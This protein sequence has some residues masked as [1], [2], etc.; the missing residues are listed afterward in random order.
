MV[1]GHKRLLYLSSFKADLA[2]A[3]LYGKKS[4][5]VTPGNYSRNALPF[6][7]YHV[8]TNIK[9]ALLFADP[10]MKLYVLAADFLFTES[11]AIATVLQISL[12]DANKQL[13]FCVIKNANHQICLLESSLYVVECFLMV[14]QTLFSRF[15]DDQVMRMRAHAVS[16]FHDFLVVFQGQQAH[17]TRGREVL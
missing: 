4:A 3:L 10:V 17:F 1:F 7:L 6:K 13:H 2:S 8:L 14:H 12:G 16:A 15:G 9:A 11:A 5:L